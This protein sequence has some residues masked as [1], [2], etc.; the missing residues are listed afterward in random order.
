MAVGWG[1]GSS[2]LHSGKLGNMFKDYWDAGELRVSLPLMSAAF[3][4]K[5]KLINL[6][7]LDVKSMVFIR[8]FY[9]RVCSFKPASR[10]LNIPLTRIVWIT[11]VLKLDFKWISVWERGEL[12]QAADQLVFLASWHS[13][14][15]VSD[16]KLTK[17]RAPVGSK[18][19]WGEM[20]INRM[21]VTEV[22]C[23]PVFEIQTG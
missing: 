1:G 19:R 16:T 14:S 8:Y 2:N 3:H 10:C 5:E 12:S 17:K 6:V 15:G 11:S 21:W 20:M 13:G 7:W 22:M 4:L 9:Y 23:P 18:Q